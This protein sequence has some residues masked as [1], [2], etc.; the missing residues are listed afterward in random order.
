MSVVVS[1]PKELRSPWGR[2]NQRVKT[3]ARRNAK[4]RRTGEGALRLLCALGQFPVLL[5]LSS[6]TVPRGDRIY[7]GGSSRT[8]HFWGRWRPWLTIRTLPPRPPGSQPWEYQETPTE[9]GWGG[10]P[11]AGAD[12]WPGFTQSSTARP[13]AAVGPRSRSRTLL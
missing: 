12:T 4:Q 8:C 2:R 7:Q 1:A 10:G 5:G 9:R 3:V 13:E 11:K 6:P